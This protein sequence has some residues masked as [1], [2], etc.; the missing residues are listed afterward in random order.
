MKRRGSSARR[1]KRSGRQRRASV[2]PSTARSVGPSPTQAPTEPEAPEADGN[3][4]H[5]E[6][7]LSKL[8]DLVSGGLW[9]STDKGADLPPERAL[10]RVAG[11]LLKATMIATYFSTDDAGSDPDVWVPNCIQLRQHEQID[12]LTGI[13]ALL[14]A[15]PIVTERL[16]MEDE[17]RESGDRVEQREALMAQAGGAR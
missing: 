9:V 1:A 7:Y 17:F 4:R 3:T 15:G 13:I 10:C 11:S 6:R 5:R 16:L 8:S 14:Q 2:P 12:A